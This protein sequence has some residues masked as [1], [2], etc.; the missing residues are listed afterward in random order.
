MKEVLLWTESEAESEGHK[1]V[2]VEA[3]H[4]PPSRLGLVVCLCALTV[5]YGTG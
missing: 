3:L 1:K 2:F 5:T 4:P